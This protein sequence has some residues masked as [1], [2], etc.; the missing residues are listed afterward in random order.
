MFDHCLAQGGAADA[1][2]A[3]ATDAQIRAGIAPG[4]VPPPTA[5]CCATGKSFLTAVCFPIAQLPRPQRRAAQG[6]LLR[7]CQ[8]NPLSC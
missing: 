8:R 1:I 4:N 2:P 5:T 6:K 3:D 7:L